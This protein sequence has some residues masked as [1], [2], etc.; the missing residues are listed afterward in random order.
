M[1]HLV[2]M[3]LQV[4]VPIVLSILVPVFLRIFLSASNLR[5]G[6]YIPSDSGVLGVLV[7]NIFSLLIYLPQI[8]IK[9]R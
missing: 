8:I 4:F 9:T 5:H 7:N 2:P 6:K 1:C 3:V